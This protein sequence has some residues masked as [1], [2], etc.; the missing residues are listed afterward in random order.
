MAPPAEGGEQLHGMFLQP[1]QCFR[2][3]D[4]MASD[5]EQHAENVLYRPTT[6]P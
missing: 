1:D 5:I 2:E 6:V 3:Q 4:L